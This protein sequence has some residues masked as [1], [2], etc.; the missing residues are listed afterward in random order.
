VLACAGGAAGVVLAAVAVA[1]L[2]RVG[3]AVLPR[4][5]E[6]SIDGGVLLFAL[7][8]T[9]LSA[10]VFG[11]LPALRA[12]GGT[13]T[14]A[15]RAS[16]RSTTADR[17]AVRLRGALVS[18]QI[19]LAVVL[20]V[21]ASLLVRTA[22]ELARQDLGFEPRGVIALRIMPQDQYGDDVARLALYERLRTSLARVPG[23]SD[24]ALANHIPLTRASMPTAVRTE[25][26]TA[27][28]ENTLA[29]FRSVSSNYLQLIGAR[30]VRGRLFDE[31]AAR[32]TGII[33]N[34]TL[35]RREW[36]DADPT[37]RPITVFRSAQGAAGFGEPLASHVLGVIADM[38]EQA[39]DQTPVPTVYVPLE[40]NVWTNI[41]VVVSTTR[42][43][44]TL[45]PALRAA[46]GDVDA[47]IP[48][49][50][51]GF[52]HEFRPLD[53]YYAAVTLTRRFMMSLLGAFA[54]VALALALTGLFALLAFV[55]AQ[56]TREIGVRMALGARRRDAA[57]LVLRQSGV[58]I[59]AGL[60][61]GVAAS[62]PATRVLE[63]TLFGVGRYDATSYITT[64][65]L[66][67]VAGG[68]AAYLP[69]RRAARVDPATALRGE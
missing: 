29:L 1:L 13:V 35:A 47:A 18:A 3:P 15:M 16:G 46:V 28:D 63:A 60:A 19:A 25:R 49:A 34:E 31:A 56:R 65:A 61:A 69:A 48:T 23:V 43:A 41:N 6:V 58:L 36:G 30:A 64:C 26:V 51:P 45:I 4:V 59:G 62:V 68:I 37:G 39:P 32:G 33:V 67:L 5:E 21:G 57:A 10:L 50:G 8:V 66:F 24:V 20:L 44:D 40:R 27:A 22:R 42:A 12:T 53:D 38:R 2:R 52:H 54:A 7:A 14:D 9:L 55:V 17:P 11:A